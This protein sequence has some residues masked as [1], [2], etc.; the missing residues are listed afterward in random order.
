MN[1]IKTTRKPRNMIP[2]FPMGEGGR[3]SLLY[4]LSVGRQC[5]PLIQG[6]THVTPSHAVL[7]ASGDPVRYLVP[8]TAKQ[9]ESLGWM[10]V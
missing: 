4:V 10:E 5:N 6:L 9:A 1:V 3:E 8:I 2:A 7:Q